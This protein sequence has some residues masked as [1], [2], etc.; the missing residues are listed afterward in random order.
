MRTNPP[1]LLP[2][3]R[4]Q[5]Q[6]NLLGLTLLQPDRRWS[7]AELTLLLGAPVSSVHRELLRA[8]DAGLLMRDDS[9]RPHR[10]AAAQASPAYPPLRDLLELTVGVSQR[11][12]KALI[13][14]KGVR[15]AAIH[16][17]WAAGRVTPSS[18][19]DVVVVL[20][21]DARE[22]QREIRQI[23]RAAGREADISLLS[24]GDAREMARLESPFWKKLVNGPRIDLVGDIASVTSS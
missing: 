2:L 13:E 6:V 12:R 1:S 5:M 16:G 20:D 3:F 15:A 23:V 7:L 4:S 14:A 18:D 9:Q 22:A 10:F 8:V 17:S 21:G 24:S 19:L 11:L